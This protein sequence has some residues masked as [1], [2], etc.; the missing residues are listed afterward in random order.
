MPYKDPE[1]RRTY[2][3]EYKR[4]QR[5]AARR[6]N[7][8]CQT[9]SNPGRARQTGKRKAYICPKVPNYRIAGIGAFKNGFFITELLEE[10]QRIESDPLYGEEI[11]SWVLEP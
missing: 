1:E 11:F 10:Q 2:Q 5:A 7:P 6:A 9:W 4:R 8:K 3:R